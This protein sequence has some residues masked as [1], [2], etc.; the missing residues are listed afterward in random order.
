MGATNAP[1]NAFTAIIDSVGHQG[2]FTRVSTGQAVDRCNLQGDTAGTVT[3]G[4]G[5]VSLKEGKTFFIQS[6]TLKA[7]RLSNH[8]FAGVISD[9]EIKERYTRRKTS[10]WS[11]SAYLT[12]NLRTAHIKPLN[13]GT[14]Q[15]LK[16]STFLETFK[17]PTVL[18]GERPQSGT[19]KTTVHIHISIRIGGTLQT[20]VTQGSALLW[21]Q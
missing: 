16:E 20:S 19:C 7:Q 12:R 17:Q 2:R 11:A 1:F 14:V 15:G 8:L 18:P 4:A 13:P 6:S 21:I 9:R 3:V 10:I 5:N